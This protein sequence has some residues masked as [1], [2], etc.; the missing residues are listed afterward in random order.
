MCVAA[1]SVQ[2]LYPPVEL[3]RKL[4]ALMSQFEINKV[5]MHLLSTVQNVAIQM[6]SHRCCLPS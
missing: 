6:P 4:C 2:T 1:D 5:Q 3:E